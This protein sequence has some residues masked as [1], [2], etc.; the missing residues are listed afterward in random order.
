MIG[1]RRGW[2]G[3]FRFEF[4]ARETMTNTKRQS[5]TLITATLFSDI[6]LVIDDPGSPRT[7]KR[8]NGDGE[9]KRGAPKAGPSGPALP[10]KGLA[11]A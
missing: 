4:F 9:A 1:M 5:K 10:S 7:A 8:L 6:P 2:G 11:V 3:S